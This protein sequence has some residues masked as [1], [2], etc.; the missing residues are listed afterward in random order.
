MKVGP[1]AYDDGLFATRAIPKGT[2]FA[3]SGGHVLSEVDVQRRIESYKPQLTQ[4][5]E[6]DLYN[7]H[8]LRQLYELTWMYRCENSNIE[9]HVFLAISK[10]KIMFK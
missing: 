1:S 3:L 5:V 2:V 4:W 7:D 10:G 8:Q 6:S 9:D